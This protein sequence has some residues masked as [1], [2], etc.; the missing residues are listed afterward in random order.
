[1]VLV[2]LREYYIRET[3]QLEICH[4]TSGIASSHYQKR[5]RVNLPPCCPPRVQGKKKASLFCA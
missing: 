5:I 2:G 1:M 4:A 3:T